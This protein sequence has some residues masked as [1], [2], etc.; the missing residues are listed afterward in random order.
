LEVDN[1]RGRLRSLL[2]GLDPEDTDDLAKRG[3]AA[4]A[5]VL[6]TPIPTEVKDTILAAHGRLKERLGRSPALAVRSSATAEDLPDASFAGQ[7]ESYLN[8]P[9]D[10]L[11]PT[12]QQ[13]MAS[14]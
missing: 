7:H 9:E 13:C 1:L 2:E 4:R 5:L 6:Q 12:V 14:L 10:Q 3:A 11:I 8:V